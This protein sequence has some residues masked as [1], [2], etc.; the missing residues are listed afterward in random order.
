MGT[1]GMFALLLM[2]FRQSLAWFCERNCPM[3]GAIVPQD[4]VVPPHMETPKPKPKQNWHG[5][6]EHLDRA[7]GKWVSDKI[8]RQIVPE[9]SFHTHK[10]CVGVKYGLRCE[11]TAEYADMFSKHL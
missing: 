4:K 2:A 5:L 3:G 1:P 11:C 10:D 7:S 6:N 9:C 8:P